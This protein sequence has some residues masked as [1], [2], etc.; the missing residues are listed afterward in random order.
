VGTDIS[1][2]LGLKTPDGYYTQYLFS[3]PGEAPANLTIVYAGTT[4]SHTVSLSIPA[5]GVANHSVYSDGTVPIGFVGAAR[6][7]STVPISAVLFRAKKVNVNS[8]ADE[9]LYTAVNGVPSANASTTQFLPLVFR[10]VGKDATHDG[11]NSWI[12]V[13]VP[14]GGIATLTLR[15][16]G[17]CT[18]DDFDKPYTTTKTITGSF[19]FYQNADSDNGFGENPVC[20]DGGGT[21]TSTVP[22]LAVASAINDLIPADG[23]GVYNG[24]AP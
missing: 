10:R 16:R 12:S 17:G 9:A 24:V 11:I 4:G 8:E 21:I 15:M 13:S 19:V 5:G 23:E 18:A 22:I 1:L 6:V 3:N 14:G 7:T 20:F 2:P